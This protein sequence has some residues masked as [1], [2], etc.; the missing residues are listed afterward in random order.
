[1]AAYRAFREPNLISSALDPDTFED[2]NARRNRYALYWAFFENNAYRDVHHWARTFRTQYGL[3]RYIRGIYNP[4]YRLGEFWKAHIFRGHLDPFESGQK[5]SAIPIVTDNQALRESINILWQWSNWQINKSILALYGSVLGDVIV[6]VV[7]DPDRQKVY[8]KIE[9]P[10][11]VKSIEL[12]DFGN[13]KGY[14]KEYNRRHPEHDRTVTYREEATRNGDMVVYTTYLND[15]P[16]PWNGSESQ[17]VEPYGF[18]PMVVIQHNNV[19]LDWGWSEIHATRH[20]FQEADD[21]A[22]K[23]NDQIRKMVD[24][25]TLFA[26]VAKPTT[27]PITTKTQY[28][29]GS[30]SDIENPF[31]GREE[32]NALYGPVGA[33]ATPIV[34]P[35]NIEHTANNIQA[36]LAEMERDH[37]ELQM[38]IWTGGGDTSGRAL[39]IARQRVETK[40]VERRAA[41]DDAMRRC[42]QMGVAIGGYR[43]YAGFEGF[44][45]DSYQAGDLDHSIGKRPVFARDPMDDIEIDAAFWQAAKTA[46][47]SGM[48]LV[49]FLV[50]Q[51]WDDERIALIVND[52]TYQNQINL[53]Q[54]AMG[55][56]DG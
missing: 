48:P 19:G 36:I 18:I 4:T 45:L 53:A 2:F 22:S 12:D 32:M 42:N 26:G 3:Y 34:A 11:K 54:M 39:R 30:T 56:N 28:T 5:Y 51:G 47:D 52:P 41:Y 23:L 20:K 15:S 49:P 31:P 8:L 35:L 16:Y 17:W 13:V 9:H 10:G 25:P 21:Q 50:D 1:M 24:P 29:S 33:T 44:G 6:E 37:P 38:D 55:L 43:Q 46:K 40:V 7:D 14:V 27:T